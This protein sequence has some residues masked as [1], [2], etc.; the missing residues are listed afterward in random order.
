MVDKPKRKH[1]KGAQKKWSNDEIFDAVCREY[2][3]QYHKKKPKGA[4]YRSV[5]REMGAGNIGEFIRD[6]SDDS[7]YLQ[8]RG[9]NRIIWN[10]G[11]GC[12]RS[13]PQRRH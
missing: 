12:R 5:A 11:N 10:M 7:Y 3:R 9:D 13:Y 8:S 1:K 6:H 2:M 4:L